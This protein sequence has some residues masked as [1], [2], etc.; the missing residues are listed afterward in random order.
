MLEC[1]PNIAVGQHDPTIATAA[2]RSLLDLHV[3]ADHQRAVVTLAG[4]GMRDAESA[5]RDV[6]RAVVAKHSFVGYQG[7]HPC[8]G[9]VDVV[10]FVALG[11]TDRVDAAAAARDFGSWVAGALD[12]PVFFYGDADEAGRSLPSLRREAFSARPPDHGPAM[13]HPRLGA[14]AVGARPPLVAINCWLDTSD[15]ALAPRIA[16]A[17][18][19]RD[20]GLPGVRALGLWLRA[21][22]HAQVSMNVTALERTGVEA[23]CEKVRDEALREG[24]EVTAVELVG[25]VPVAEYERWSDGFRRWSGIGPD[26]TIE[27]RLGEPTA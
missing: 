24:A 23:A 12:L 7:L 8:V 13:P 1:V 20:G 6:A 10:P 9:V 15:R 21:A 11:R 4:P 16:A 22:G 18:R 2:G 27:A 19:E 14:T 26:H 25:L 5:M 17:V 3:D